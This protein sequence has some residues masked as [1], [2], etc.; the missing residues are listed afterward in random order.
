MDLCNIENFPQN[1]KN[2]Y[3]LVV[4]AG[5]VNNNHMDYLLFEQMIL[6]AKQSGLVMF[7]ARFSFLGVYWYN[8]ICKMIEDENRW[9]LI[10][11]EAFY[12]YDRIL[13]SVGRF[14]KTPVKT[15]CY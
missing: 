9:K 14:S 2:K 7:A 10:E 8:D 6:A 15:Y 4:C 3:D 5:T 13:A 12:K 1:F 11:E